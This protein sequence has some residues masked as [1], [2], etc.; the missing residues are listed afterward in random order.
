M[1]KL[2]STKEVIP[3]SPTKKVISANEDISFLLMD[4]YL[5]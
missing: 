5:N 4:C 3:P 2:N 1:T